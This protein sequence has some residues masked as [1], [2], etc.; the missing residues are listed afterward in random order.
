MEARAKTTPDE[1]RGR[2]L[3]RSALATVG[4]VALLLVAACASLNRTV[5][6]PLQI[7][8]ATHVGSAACT[9]CHAEQSRW[10]PASPHGRRDRGGAQWAETAGCESCHGPGSRHVATSSPDWIIN[11][12][13]NPEACFACHLHTAA[14]FR[15]PSHHPLL[16][17]RMDCVSCHDPHGMEI[18]QPAGGLAMARE[19]ATCGS[20]HRAQHRPFVFE[21]E[22]MREGCTVC[23]T[24]HGS[25]NAKLLTSPGAHLCLKCHAQNQTVAGQVVIGKVDHTSFLRLGGCYTAGCHMAVHGSNLQPKLRY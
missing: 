21:H 8:G 2:R 4:V 6:V 13:R 25:I 10:F 11:P 12:R 20:C 16:E 23:H 15:M 22:A 24:P 7:E 3:V 5:V 1:G 9:E 17:G 18:L 14:E 19:N